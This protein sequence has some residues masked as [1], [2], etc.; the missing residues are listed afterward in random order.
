M[1]HLLLWNNIAPL[2]PLTLSVVY[3]YYKHSELSLQFHTLLVKLRPFTRTLY[4]PLAKGGC[5]LRWWLSS[6]ESACKARDLGQEDP[7]EK[8]MGSGVYK[9]LSHVWLFATLWIAARQAPLSMEFSRQEY[10]N[11]YA[12]PSPG[13][14]PDPGIESR[15]PTL[16]A[17]S[18]PSEPRGNGNLLQYFCLRN[19][20]HREVWQATTHEVTKETQ[21]SN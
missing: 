14:L 4:I 17:D 5:G 2:T 16:Q 19:P 3:I 12:F 15:S 13:D 21:P 7:R 20:I 1:V 6:K 18:L 11:G 10:G 8:E 9:S